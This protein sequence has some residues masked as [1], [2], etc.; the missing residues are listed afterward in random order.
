MANVL[1]GVSG[2]VAAYRAADLARDLMRAGHQVRVCLTRSAAN[3]VTPALFEALTGEVCLVDVFEEPARGRMAHIDLAR[4]ADL[5]LVAP[6]TAHTLASL[7]HGYAEDMLTTLVLASEAPLAVAP[8]M[9]PTMFDD[10]ATRSA[11]EALRARAALVIEPQSGDVACGENG[12]GKLASNAEI[13]SASTALLAVRRLWEGRT[14]LITSGPTEEAIDDVRM[15]TN[16]SSGKMGSALARAGLLMG[17]RVMVVAGPQR[18]P[19]PI[20]AEVTRVR[21]AQDMLAAALP[22]ASQ[23]N[24]I[25]GAAAVADYRPAAR[26]EGKHRSGEAWS[27][28][29]VPNPD[30][31]KALAEAAPQALLCAFAAE[32]GEG[33]EKAREKMVRKGVHAVALNNVSD[34]AIGFDSDDNEII[35]IR[36]QAD[37]ERS[38]RFSKINCALWLLERLAAMSQA[39]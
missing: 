30:V 21:S 18:A 2:S 33:V 19:L 9:N 28:E 22:L 8:A 36:S 17:A 35:L 13:L 31:L 23:A 32:P 26:F 11:L 39:S 29:L 3:F 4:W 15:L 25:V 24:L 12:Q 27:I 1:L 38:P 6:A 16:R 7:A 37:P 34:S 20:Q 10:P 5:I 14:I